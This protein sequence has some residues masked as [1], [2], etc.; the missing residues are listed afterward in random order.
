MFC[1]AGLD[2]AFAADRVLIHEFDDLLAVLI[3]NDLFGK[4]RLVVD[5]VEQRN[6]LDGRV[7]LLGAFG[8]QEFRALHTEISRFTVL[9][10]IFR[11][12]FFFLRE[13]LR[14]RDPREFLFD[15]VLI[16]PEFFRHRRAVFKMVIHGKQVVEKHHARSVVHHKMVHANVDAVSAVGSAE[17]FQ[18]VGLA[19]EHTDR[20]LRVRGQHFDLLLH[21]AELQN[22]DVVNLIVIKKILLDLATE[23]ANR[24]LKTKRNT[25]HEILL[26]CSEII[27]E[28]ASDMMKE[29]LNEK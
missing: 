5:R 6:I 22:R 24:A 16:L 19:L 2:Q 23:F 4:S 18:T 26:K 11:I 27:Q 12:G 3:G 21:G 13:V 29:E 14:I 17:K 15:A 20:R 7:L 28:Y 1:G 25:E 10:D 8:I 9:G